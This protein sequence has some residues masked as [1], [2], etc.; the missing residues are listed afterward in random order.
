[1]RFCVERAG[2]SVFWVGREGR[3]LY[4]NAPRPARAA[5]M[6]VRNCWG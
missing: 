5:A 3:I 2:D 6:P 4:A 1:M